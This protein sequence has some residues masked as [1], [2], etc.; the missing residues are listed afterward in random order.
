MDDPRAAN[1]CRAALFT[2]L[3]ELTMAQAFHARGV[4]GEAAFEVIFRDLP[5]RRSFVSAVCCSVVRDS[6]LPASRLC[7]Y[8]G[9]V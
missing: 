4:D 1:P 7:C 2:D 8:H 5:A 3:Y 9:S 6:A